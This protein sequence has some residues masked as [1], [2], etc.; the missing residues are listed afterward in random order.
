MQNI[1]YSHSV[2]LSQII[3]LDQNPQRI[4][5]GTSQELGNTPCFT[6]GLAR[7]KND[8]KS[9]H[10]MLRLSDLQS[11]IFVNRMILRTTLIVQWDK[12]NYKKVSV[13]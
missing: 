10:S 3:R 1:G 5:I 9:Q 7:I 12:H 4:T 8:L 6:N 11:R 2:N 13:D